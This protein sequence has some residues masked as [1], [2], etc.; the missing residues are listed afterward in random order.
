[1]KDFEQNICNQIKLNALN[2]IRIAN[3]GHSGIVLSSAE[4]IYTLYFK[5]MNISSKAPNWANR[6]RF[7]MSAGHGSALLYSTLGMLEY[8]D[9]DYINTFRKM[10]SSLAGHPEVSTNGVDVSTGP[11]GQGIGNAVGLA[12]AESIISRKLSLSKNN[13]LSHFTY[14]LCGDG[15]L[16][17]GVALESIAIAG[18]FQLNKLILIYDKNNITLDGKL[19]D[20][21]T[22]DYAKMF[23]SNNWNVIEVENGHSIDEIDIAIIQAKKSKSKPTIIIANT[24]I[25]NQTKLEGSNKSHGAVFDICEINRLKEL[26]NLTDGFGKNE[27]EFIKK[28]ITKNYNTYLNNVE[29]FKNCKLDAPH[30]YNEICFAKERLEDFDLCGVNINKDISGRDASK[31]LLNKFANDNWNVLSV[32]VD[33]SGSTKSEIAN[34]SLYS[35]TNRL[36][37]NIH[38]GIREHAM[39]AICNGLALHGEFKVFASSFLVF[40]DYL[41][42][43]IRMASIMGL[44]VTYLFTHDSIAVGEDGATHQPIEQLDS[45]RA[46]P[47]IKLYRPADSLE[48]SA[49]YSM[50]IETKCEPSIIILSRQSLPILKSSF[51]KTKYGAYIIKKCKDVPQINLIATGSEVSI[52]IK[53][54][55]KLSKLGIKNNVI[56]I[57]CISLFEKQ[58]EKYKD[59][60]LDK[61]VLAR[62]II[63]ASSGISLEKYLGQNGKM[64]VMNTFGESGTPNQ[65]LAKYG[66]TVD[67]I[68]ENAIKLLNF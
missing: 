59:K 14:C 32:S 46:M 3:S 66:F 49:C 56:S 18:H 1:M 4:L 44:P 58:T 42:P 65:L 33:V 19:S 61:G 8:Y 64:L 37:R 30:T 17:E 48:L 35:A 62:L 53:A 41:K 9:K 57:P 11:L 2:M 16:M 15:C 38:L 55:F 52:A 25:G 20:V 54:S 13:P 39:G 47:N 68:V 45:F 26:W 27:N 63:E 51:S 67:N 21:T 60:I 6:D 29:N 24:K 31:I 36:G 5:H 22:T 12:I 40:S 43:S 7:V 28:V 23:E 10:G 50:A 34:S